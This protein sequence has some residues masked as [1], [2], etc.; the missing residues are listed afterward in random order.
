[1]TMEPLTRRI[2]QLAG[3]P[4]VA[5]PYNRVKAMTWRQ[6]Q[7]AATEALR[8]VLTMP[9]GQDV[10]WVDEVHRPSLFN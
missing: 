1:M 5:D 6:G 7:T 3:H 10:F 8:K 9:E 2:A 4:I